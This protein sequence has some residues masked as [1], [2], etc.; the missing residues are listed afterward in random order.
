MV[1]EDTAVGGCACLDTGRLAAF[2]PAARSPDDGAGGIAGHYAGERIIRPCDLFGR[3][4]D[5]A[6][7]P[8]GRSRVLVHPADAG[9]FADDPQQ[10][11][12][13]TPGED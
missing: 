8:S 10:T 9:S 4:L 11:A 2:L 12:G 1:D 7:I 13:P 3:A 5:G 6:I